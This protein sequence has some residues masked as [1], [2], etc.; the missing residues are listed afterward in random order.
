LPC[1]HCSA[2]ACHVERRCLPSRSLSEEGNTS[3]CIR[4]R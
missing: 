4:L 1:S 3:R 2:V